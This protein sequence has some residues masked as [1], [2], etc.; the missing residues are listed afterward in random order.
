MFRTREKSQLKQYKKG[1]DADE[2]RK[3]REEISVELRKNK[4][5]EQ[6]AKRRATSQA[7]SSTVATSATPAVPAPTAALIP[8]FR[9]GLMSTDP[10]K[11]A[12]CL[13]GFRQ[14]L[15]VDQ[16]PP[17]QEVLDAGVLPRLVQFLQHPVAAL[18]FE[19]AWAITNI[20]SGKSEH[21]NAVVA[22]GAIPLF[23]QLLRSPNMEVVEQ[24]IWA[25]G[26]IA[27][28]S[29]RLR[30]TLLSNGIIEPLLILLN[31]GVNPTTTRNITW[32]LSNLCRGKPQSPLDVIRPAI[33]YLAKLLASDDEE[34]VM[35]AAWAMSYISDDSTP[36]GDRITAVLQSGV[37]RRLVELLTFAK[38]D[39]KTPALRSIGN[40]VTGNDTQTQAILD[41]PVIPALV[42]LLTHPK[43]AMRKEA[44][45]TLSNITAGNTRQIQTVIDAGAIPRLVSILD[46]DAF[47]VQKEAFWAVANA[48]SGAGDSQ[49]RTLVQQG[50]I[51]CIASMIQYPAVN[52]LQV[53][54]NS[55]DNILKV[56]KADAALHG[57]DNEFADKLEETGGLDKL[58]ELQTH[59]NA[60][61]ARKSTAL[62]STYYE[63]EEEEGSIAPAS[64][65]AAFSFGAPA[66]SNN[67]FASAST[68]G[69]NFAPT[70]GFSF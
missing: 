46:D 40:I 31:Q 60:E 47:E 70:G 42:T 67:P 29:T 26:N 17:I 24:A 43:T 27:G 30:D 18:Q 16:N 14:M 28:D 19:A 34:V 21:T 51:G 20:A 58:E 48:T 57:G 33:P 32:T 66:G 13:K 68:G 50:I 1:V 69:F 39:I 4:R 53:A 38:V 8:A 2:S 41:F 37:A 54:L 7:P 44:C 36:R 6:I 5:E 22:S 65:G 25:L 10:A 64:N 12:D 63:S 52:M 3:K 62:L 35:D 23:I 61:I 15:S 49:I 9:E 45:W 55:L 56:G 59:D 11:H